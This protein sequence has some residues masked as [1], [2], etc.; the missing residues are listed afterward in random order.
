MFPAFQ[1]KIKH[2]ESQSNIILGETRDGKWANA[3]I[4]SGALELKTVVLLSAF[5]KFVIAHTMIVI[6][7]KI[8]TYLQS[9]NRNVKKRRQLKP[10]V[11]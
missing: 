9:F 3:A 5:V 7:N 11:P 6:I 4:Q 2:G 8:M 10:L 1:P